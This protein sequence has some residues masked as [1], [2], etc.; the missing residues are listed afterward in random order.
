MLST[1]DRQSIAA[2]H[3]DSLLEEL[4][5]DLLVEL[6]EIVRENQLAFLPFAKSGRADAELLEKHAY[7]AGQLE[8]ARERRID[9]MQLRSRLHEDEGRS[10][11]FKKFR[12]GSLDRNSSSP[13]TPRTNRTSSRQSVSPGASP[14]LLPEDAG[15][16]LL[17]EMDDE[18][19]SSKRR[20]A[21]SS[22]PASNPV[23]PDLRP[24]DHESHLEDGT[25]TRR[26]DE[27]FDAKGRPLASS[28]DMG[29]PSLG[30]SFPLPQYSGSPSMSRTPNTTTMTTGFGTKSTPWSNVTSTPTKTELRDIMAEA[31]V[32]RPSNLTLAMNAKIS[33]TA[34]GVQK[35]SQK[36]RKKMQQQQLQKQKD[37]Q[38]PAPPVLPSQ[39]ESPAMPKSPWQASRP[40]SK[41]GSTEFAFVG[42]PVRDTKMDQVTRPPM[43]A[44]MTM[45]QTVARTPP[46]SRSVSTPITP[47]SKPVPPQ[48][49]SIRHNTTSSSSN[50]S[51]LGS[52]SM[53]DILSQQQMQKIAVK[54]AVAKRSL[55]EIQQQ[56][57]FEE[58][59]DSESRRLQEEEAQISAAAAAATRDSR[60]KRGRGRGGHRNGSGRGGTKQTGAGL[61]TS[62]TVARGENTSVSA[63]E[64]APRDAPR[65]PHRGR[66]G[67]RG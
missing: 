67:R 29:P 52:S 51:E 55:Q 30:S 63:V 1:S 66:G 37:V 38:P 33:E 36:E 17:F 28:L 21:R 18:R 50:L 40:S 56:Q 53:A 25:P 23:S 6:G 65:H 16:D 35:L 43:R 26:E 61:S 22:N 3:D 34:K 47:S 7:L 4:D 59:F 11:S 8:Q 12:V 24:L 14:S 49:K 44:A 31:S 64:Q 2:N 20:P 41:Q 13:L 39:E 15:S 45:R 54:E 46:P 5:E 48:I 62:P 9:S 58:W 10:G 27:W 19:T 32:T 57:E 42:S 60:G